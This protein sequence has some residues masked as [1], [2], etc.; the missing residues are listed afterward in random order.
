MVSVVLSNGSRELG[1]HDWQLQL[2][3]SAL[4]QDF[5]YRYAPGGGSPRWWMT[6]QAVRSAFRLS[7]HKW[8]LVN[9]RVRTARL[10]DKF[11]IE[12]PF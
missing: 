11:S 6:F 12:V 10:A 3:Y 8:T 7:L 2:R 5:A 4:R 1:G 9:V